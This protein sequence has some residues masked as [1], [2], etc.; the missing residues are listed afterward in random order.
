MAGAPEI[1]LLR[2]G[3]TEWSLA[4]RHTGLTDVPLSEAG[5]RQAEA[6]GR[7]L[8]GRRLPT[9]LTSPLGRASETCRL[10]GF[11]D[12][13]TERADLVEWDYGDHE[14][15][16][17][18]HVREAEPGWT[19]WTHPTPG[20]ETVAQVGARV[21]RLV[22]ELAVIESDAAVFSHGHLLRV[23]GAR[24]IGLAPEDGALLA[25]STGTL[26]VLGWERERRVIRLWNDSSHLEGG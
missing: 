16:T 10:A 9:V 5:R 25:L 26:S 15:L 21:D 3:E 18:A 2:H 1:L 7:R 6:L 14:G 17:T 24:W 22:A 8:R 23:L 19:V 20:A 4:G 13:C 11:G 12:R